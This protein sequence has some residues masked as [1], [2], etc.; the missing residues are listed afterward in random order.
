MFKPTKPCILPYAKRTTFIQGKDFF[1]LTVRK[2]GGVVL[3]GSHPRLQRR[4]CRSEHEAIAAVKKLGW[5][6]AA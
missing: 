4:V 3:D 5:Q 1:N 2:L 6:V